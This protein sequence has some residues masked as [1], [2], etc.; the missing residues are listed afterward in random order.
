MQTRKARVPALIGFLCAALLL[1]SACG[2]E[3]G[4]AK[5]AAPEA[6]GARSTSP[7]PAPAADKPIKIRIGWQPTG[8]G[9][10]YF[11]A[12]AQDLFKKAG[13][14][15][16]SVKF[17]AAPPM[18]AAFQSNSIDVGFWGTPPAVGGLA[19]GV[20]VK[21]ILLENDASRSEGLVARKESGIKELKDL[22]GKRVATMRGTSA[23]YALGKALKKAG[24][25]EKDVQVI[26]IN[27]AQV[28]P[29]WEKGD[30]DAALYWEPWLGQMR[31]SGGT[32][33]VN[34]ADVGADGG[35]VWVARTEFIKEN[36]EAIQRLLKAIDMA[37]EP[38][39]KKTDAAIDAITKG[40]GAD[41]SII[42]ILVRDEAVWPALEEIGNPGYKYSM[43]PDTIAKGEGLAAM[44]NALA[45]FQKENGRIKEVPNFGTAIDT[46]PLMQYLQ[47]KGGK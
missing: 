39:A 15:V 6:A 3:S 13:L 46:A 40:I 16:E 12:Q 19:Q 9:G 23:D 41:R 7:A 10:R 22:K 28:M 14:E 44:L 4:P 38:L 24:L 34:D 11:V 29:A 33:I 32:Q 2:K 45:T 43:H 37:T 42:E 35:I 25:T 31:K 8:N 5:P 18:Y 20:P 27:V 36:P 26:D 1:L 17:T 30:I 21:I 47:A